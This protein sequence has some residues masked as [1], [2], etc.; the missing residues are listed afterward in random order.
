MLMSP[1]GWPSGAL[2]LFDHGH[3][4][5]GQS[6]LIHGAAGVLGS[7]ATQLACWAGA[8]VIGTG[9]STARR[10]APD[11]GADQF[12]DLESEGWEET[13]AQVDVVFDTIGD[14]VVARSVGIVKSGGALIT[15]VAPPPADRED[16]RMVHFVRDPSRAQLVKLAE[17]V[18]SGRVRPQVGAVYPLAQAQTAFATKANHGVTGKVILQP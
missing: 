4:Q 1:S 6:V 15:V 11:L 13:V 5:S 10:I 17:L 2:A 9:R 7:M 8:R 18:D 16:I 14:D 3:L 12:V